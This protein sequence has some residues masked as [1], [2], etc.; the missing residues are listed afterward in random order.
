[1]KPRAC[2]NGAKKE[3]EELKRLNKDCYLTA[4]LEAVLHIAVG[5]RVMLRRNTITSL[6]LVNGALF[7]VVA[8]G[9]HKVTVKFD[10]MSTEY[11]IER[12]KTRFLVMRRVYIFRA[13]FPLI[14]AYA[15]TIH[16][17]QGLSLDCAM[18][19][20]FDEVFSSGMAYVALSRVRTLDGVHLVALDRK[21]I[22]V[23]SKS[24]L[25]VN[26]L[27]QLH[28]LDLMVYALPCE[29]SAN[30]KRKLRGTCTILLYPK[31]QKNL[32]EKNASTKHAPIRPLCLTKQDKGQL[33]KKPRA[34]KAKKR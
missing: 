13:Q 34:R 25:E 10:H 31:K 32:K 33:A 23:S 24:L 18:M 7:T 20:L 27:R 12:V 14:F 26:R 11:K 1:M 29:Q 4:G 9:V 2:T 15:V 3:A 30:R 22:M 6:G 28:R 5:A 21:S 8:I 17:C 19:D 16:R